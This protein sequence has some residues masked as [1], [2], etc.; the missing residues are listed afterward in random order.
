V[1]AEGT[2]GVN[3][4]PEVRGRTRIQGDQ[5]ALARRRELAADEVAVA[6]LNRGTRNAAQRAGA[7][8][9]VCDA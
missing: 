2:S 9:L 1:Q 4:Q 5:R 7:A 6:V 3:D 8:A